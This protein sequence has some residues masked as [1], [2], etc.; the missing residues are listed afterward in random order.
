[1]LDNIAS[2]CYNNNCQG[3]TVTTTF[4]RGITMNKQQIYQGFEIEF[5]AGKILSPVG[6]IA[7]LL[8]NGNA[9]LGKGVWTFS[10]LAGNVEYNATVNG[11]SVT[12]KGTCNC[13]CP[14]CYAQTGFY[15]MPSTVNALAV[16]TIIAREHVD[17]MKRA[18]IA[19]IMADK[20]TL[21]RIHASGDFIGS[22]FIKAWYD[23]VNASPECMFWTYTKNMEA[24][25]AFDDLSNCNVVKSIIPNV[26]FNFG[27]CDYIMDVY[28]TLKA[29]KKSV[30]VC[31]CGFDKSQHCV[32]C[33]GCS[34]NEYV[35]FV[36]HST[37]YKAESDPMYNNLL[38]IAIG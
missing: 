33:K 3:N 12:V 37:A 2:I 8:V 5:K 27:H 35:L 19:Q 21:C 26:G 18:I 31:K 23:I 36:E 16:R 22:E 11:E 10:T 1:M 29:A 14:G 6:W 17:F 7:P 32:N 28:E 30:H 25:N 13:N 38:K 4:E 34:E 20:I 24:E 9:K 15:K